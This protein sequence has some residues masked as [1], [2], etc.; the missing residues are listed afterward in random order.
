MGCS[1]TLAVNHL[2]PEV[3]ENHDN[4]QDL[5]SC[6][7]ACKEIDRD[8]VLEVVP[9]KGHPPLGPRPRAP[10]H[11]SLRQSI[12]IPRSLVSE[13]PLE[14]AASPIA[15][16]RPRSSRS[17]PGSP[18]APGVGQAWVHSLTLPNAFGTSF[19]SK[20]SRSQAERIQ[21]P[22][23]QPGQLRDN[24]DQKSRSAARICGRRLVRSR[25]KIWCR[26]ARNSASRAARDWSRRRITPTR[27]SRRFFMAPDHKEADHV[28]QVCPEGSLKLQSRRKHGAA[29]RGGLTNQPC[30]RS[31]NSQVF[32]C[33]RVFG[34]DTSFVLDS[35]LRE[36]HNAVVNR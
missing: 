34:N 5:E 7:R 14:C 27:R 25:T 30:V 2:P 35:R 21:A 24:H 1:V 13:A 12:S 3:D 28:P 15:D 10:D 32:S 9:K 23:R 29:C 22:P 16:L 26:R 20:R 31:S 8:P 17:I 33:R 11:V 19:F 4:E 6:R 36:L 18:S